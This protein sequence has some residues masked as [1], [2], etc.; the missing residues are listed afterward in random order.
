MERL[1]VNNRNL[2]NKSCPIRFHLAVATLL[3]PFYVLTTCSAS[4]ASG[5]PAWLSV[6]SYKGTVH[7]KD[8]IKQPDMITSPQERDGIRL[9]T[10]NQQLQI[11]QNSE[12]GFIFRDE[13]DKKLHDNAITGGSKNS[14]TEYWYPCSGKGTFTIAWKAGNKSKPCRNF[15]VSGSTVT[16]K[17]SLASWENASVAQAN[18]SF[19]NAQQRRIDIDRPIDMEYCNTV[20]DSGKGW[21]FGSS[22]NRIFSGKSPCET[23]LEK[24]SETSEGSDCSVTSWATW[25]LRERNLIVSRQCDRSTPISRRGTGTTIATTVLLEFLQEALR[26][27]ASSCELNVY[28]SDEIII[29]PV[30]DQLTLVHTDR[31]EDGAIVVNVIAG[32]V[33][34]RAATNLQAPVT[35]STGNRRIFYGNNRFSQEELLDTQQVASSPS[36]QGFLN[37]ENWP[38]DF[39]PQLEEYQNAINRAIPPQ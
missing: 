39:T 14:P 37:S 33:E 22:V 32:T 35:V 38:R 16:E 34:I 23:A 1:P 36:V 25:N 4:L 27:Q 7:F 29:S 21:G 5:L 15:K 13:V 30:N 6:A 20:A 2:W 31:S 18:K 9:K 17:A 26:S 8:G 3:T 19:L 24:C 12:A 28:R 10:P 11:T